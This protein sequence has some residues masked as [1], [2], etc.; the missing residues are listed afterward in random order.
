[1]SSSFEQI[2]QIV[3]LTDSDIRRAAG[4]RVRAG[5][6]PRPAADGGSGYPDSPWV[7]YVTVE[8]ADQLRRALNPTGADFGVPKADSP[9]HSGLRGGS[10][11]EAIRRLP[12]TDRREAVRAAHFACF[13]APTPEELR[14]V[15]EGL[16]L[17]PARVGVVAVQDLTIAAGKVLVLGN[18]EDR[19]T[20]F[21]LVVEN[22][23]IEAGGQL[24][25]ASPTSLTVLNSLTRGTPTEAR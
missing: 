8:T 12:A 9:K 23:T 19:A 22:L 17:L 3:G 15:S 10:W 20:P 24:V 4:S 5:G 2:L 11:S 25:L 7:H 21:S 18:R 13:G 1:M 6:E 14:G 16:G